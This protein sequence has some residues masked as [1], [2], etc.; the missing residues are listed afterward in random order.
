MRKHISAALA[1]LLLLLG[2]GCQKTPEKSVVTSKND[3]TFEAALEN[4]PQAQSTAE[5]ESDAA[6]APESAVYTDSFE[7]ANGSI[8]Y[9]LSLTAPE[10]PSA[11]PVVQ[12]RPME[13]TPELAQKTAQA[14]FG[15]GSIYEYTTQH[16][17][18]ELEAA[19]LEMKES[20]SDWD[21]L[22]EGCGGDEAIA[23]SYKAMREESIAAMEASYAA[24]PDTVDRSP[25]DWQFRPSTYYEDVTHLGHIS[26]NGYQ[27]CKAS[28][29]LDGVP[30]VFDA[31]NLEKD[32]FREHSITIGAD[33]ELTD[34][35]ALWADTGERPDIPAVQE[36]ALQ[37]AGAMG[38]GVWRVAE[39][40]SDINA[41]SVTYLTLTREYEGLPMTFHE[42]PSEAETAYGPSYTYEKLRMDLNGD[43]LLSILYQGALEQTGVVNENV[44]T[45]PFAD[46]LAAARTQMRLRG[47]VDPVT[48]EAL[49]ASEDGS[50]TKIAVDRVE[51]GLSRIFIKDNTA[52]YYL[53]PTYTFYGTS[54][55]RSA[56]GSPID[57]SFF[58]EA[59]G[60]TVAFP[61][62]TTVELAVINAVDGSVIDT[63]LGY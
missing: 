42:G 18:S 34:T 29:T 31:S 9:E 60:R 14:V 49:P 8:R 22:V 59:S 11:L 48:G 23:E 46:I 62:P 27:V 37:I 45:L 13:I 57:Y 41:A 51:L 10:L 50:F 36:R 40:E 7:N 55:A 5:A 16:T 20:I 12:V 32:D 47:T 52:E 25:C 61:N 43:K 38:L 28:A 17:K 54:T 15:D 1:A 21:A 63:A 35:D 26:D 19:I 39:C 33:S 3:G 6:I 24:A 30:F 2:C 53:V 56:D 58:D 44:Q 4:T